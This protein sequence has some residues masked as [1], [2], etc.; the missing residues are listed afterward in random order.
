[1]LL[2]AVLPALRWVVA[3]ALRSAARLA[4]SRPLVASV[5]R[6]TIST[7]NLWC[8][9]YRRMGT[10]EGTPKE[11]LGGSFSSQKDGRVRE[12]EFPEIYMPRHRE[13]APPRGLP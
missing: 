6:V 10:S 3:P 9:A 11:E 1:M 12:S 8:P 7:F 13:R 4:R 2:L 5:D